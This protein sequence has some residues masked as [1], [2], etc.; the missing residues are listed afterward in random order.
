MILDYF[1]KIL[2]KYNI[3]NYEYNIDKNK[4]NHLTID[5]PD[6]YVCFLNILLLK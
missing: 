2:E 6:K 1:K 3:V 5:I 4:K